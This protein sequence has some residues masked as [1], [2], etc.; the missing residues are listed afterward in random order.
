MAIAW[1]EPFVA[2]LMWTIGGAGLVLAFLK[3][4]IDLDRRTDDR[5]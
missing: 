4:W 2:I 3:V 5:D 1:W